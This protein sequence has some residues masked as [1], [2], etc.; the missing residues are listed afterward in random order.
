MRY[1]RHG[2]AVCSLGEYFFVVTGSRKDI[3]RAPF[4]TE[5]YDS[6]NDSITELG[7]IN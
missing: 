1:P 2:H 4:R 6:R 3:D 7:D 5:L